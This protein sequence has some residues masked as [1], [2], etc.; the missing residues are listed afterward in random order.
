M[1]SLDVIIFLW[2]DLLANSYR[3]IVRIPDCTRVLLVL[4]GC[5]LGFAD[6]V[7]LLAV[8]SISIVLW[9]I[10]FIFS[11]IVFNQAECWLLWTV[12]VILGGGG[13]FGR[14]LMLA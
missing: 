7:F 8:I 9:D 5:G 13:S 3:F 12:F 4:L 10:H 1:P 6:S 2:D 14:I 11:I